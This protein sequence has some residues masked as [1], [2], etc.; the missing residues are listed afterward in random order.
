LVIFL[1]CFCQKISC[2][3]DVVAAQ[4][5]DADSMVHFGHS[6]LSP[7][8]KLPVYYVFEKFSLDLD[9]FKTQLNK[10]EAGKTIV[11]Y[12]ESYHHLYG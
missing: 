6:C 12:D 4:H 5:Y 11:L 9:L 2:C 7:V 10:L 8:D 1:F 3:A